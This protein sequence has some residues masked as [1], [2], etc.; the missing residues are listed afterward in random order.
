MAFLSYFTDI[1]IEGKFFKK[2]AIFLLLYAQ[3][4]SRSGIKN[5]HTIIQNRDQEQLINVDGSFLP[6]DALKI[7]AKQS[8]YPSF[9]REAYKYN[10]CFVVRHFLVPV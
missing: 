10:K 7:L 8:P 2:S 3:L 5:I 1:R 6:V 4:I 9:N